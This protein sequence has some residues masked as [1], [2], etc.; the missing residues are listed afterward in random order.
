MIT[1]HRLLQQTHCFLAAVLYMLC[2]GALIS[3]C[4][5]ILILRRQFFLRMMMMTIITCTEHQYDNVCCSF[6]T[7]CCIHRSLV[8][9]TKWPQ[10]IFVGLDSLESNYC[11]QYCFSPS[12]IYSFANLS[13][14]SML[15]NYSEPK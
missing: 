2:L 3:D 8:T 6:V 9:F 13:L 4:F 12:V 14:E 10:W 5:C 1:V 15:V 11:I 7:V